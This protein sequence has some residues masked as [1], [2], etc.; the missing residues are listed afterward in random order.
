MTEYVSLDRL[1]S[2]NSN[3]DAALEASI[4]D[5]EE[6]ITKATLEQS[7]EE[8]KEKPYRK[9]CRSSGRLKQKMQP[10]VGS[11]SPDRI[12]ASPKRA[13]SSTPRKSLLKDAAEAQMTE[14]DQRSVDRLAA[15]SVNSNNLSADE[16]G[17]GL[18]AAAALYG[19]MQMLTGGLAG[20]AKRVSS[21]MWSDPSMNDMSD[22]CPERTETETEASHETDD[23]IDYQLP[24]PSWAGSISREYLLGM[25]S[26]FAYFSKPEVLTFVLKQ[27]DLELEA[28]KKRE[29]S[30]DIDS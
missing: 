20:I 29:S 7:T 6:L 13:R 10:G 25:R 2:W 22:S 17:I 1:W 16:D 12:L 28:S 18:G 26:H 11:P 3:V 15:S 14:R 5:A 30:T 23:R 19:A 24:L 9:R 8:H 21:R 4:D 27:T